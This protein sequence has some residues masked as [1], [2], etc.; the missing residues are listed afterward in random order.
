M[1]VDLECGSRIR[2]ARPKGRKKDP[3]VLTLGAEDETI[4]LSSETDIS[5]TSKRRS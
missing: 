5:Q 3:N 1:R 2:S 4:D